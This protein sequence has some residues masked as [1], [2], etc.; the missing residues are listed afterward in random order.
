M[1]FRTAYKLPWPPTHGPEIDQVNVLRGA[2]PP[3][4]IG[5]ERPV[6]TADVTEELLSNVSVESLKLLFLRDSSRHLIKQRFPL[7]LGVDWFD[8]FR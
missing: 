5:K 1:R 4:P 2:H 8:I 7:F 3:K 6:R